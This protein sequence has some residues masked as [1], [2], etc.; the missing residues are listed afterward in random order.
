MQTH[1]IN[2]V[3]KDFAKE[4][5]CI[6]VTHFWNSFFITKQKRTKTKRKENE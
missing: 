5:C 3:D 2:S 4:I 1:C 6:K